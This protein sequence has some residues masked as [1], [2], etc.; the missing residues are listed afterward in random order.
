MVDQDAGFALSVNRPAHNVA[1]DEVGIAEMLRPN[2]DGRPL[3]QIRASNK[4]LESC[5][6]P[7]R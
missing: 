6:V 2:V 5:R 3:Q 7:P 4:P 1:A